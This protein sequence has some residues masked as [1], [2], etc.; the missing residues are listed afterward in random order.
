[1]K[2]KAILII[3]LIASL[4]A[5]DKEDNADLNIQTVT[6]SMSD[7]YVNDVYYS[8]KNGIVAT[9]ARNTWDIAF[10]TSTR[11]SSIIIN[12]GSGVQ[13]FVYPSGS[14]WSWDDALD[15]TGLHTWNPL[16]NANENWENGAFSA[17]ATEH[18]NYGWG[19]YDMATHNINGVALYI[20]QLR[21][22]DYK[23]IWI[24]KKLSVENKYLFRFANIDGTDEQ[25][26]TLDASKYTEKLYIGYS[27]Q[28]NQVIDREPA[29]ESWD[30]L[31]TRYH[32]NT[33][34]FM[35]TGV[36][37]NIGV[38]AIELGEGNSSNTN[39]KPENFSESKSIIGHDWKSF[40][41]NSF[42]YSLEDKTYFVKDLNNNVYRIIFTDFG[43]SADG[44]ITMEQV[45]ITNEGASI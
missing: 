36:L 35:V 8:L 4:F 41:M 31:F 27:L 39:Y 15:T 33:I 1:M 9:P 23:K 34:D 19:E 11:S 7:N 14:V 37:Q 38:E 2:R 26:I 12:E 32:N 18:P 10:S 16:H 20:I 6:L 40:D 21:N 5:C 24:E 22:G 13:L 29:K 43:G 17:N 44:N 3:T 30:L 25:N 42:Q 45:F 28:E